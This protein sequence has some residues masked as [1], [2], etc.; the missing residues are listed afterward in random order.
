MIPWIRIDSNTIN[1]ECSFEGI[2]RPQHHTNW[3]L[4]LD[5]QASVLQET[6]QVL[7]HL[8]RHEVR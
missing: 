5:K 2:D 4:S 6:C 3:Y 7:W 8:T 1:T